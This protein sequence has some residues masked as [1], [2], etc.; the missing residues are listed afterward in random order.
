MPKQNGKVKTTDA[1]YLNPNGQTVVRR[2]DLRG[3]DHRQYIYVLR[4]TN[5]R[6]EYGANGSDIH[7]RKCPRC[8]GGAPGLQYSQAYLL[9]WNPERSTWTE[10]P[11]AARALRAGN[12][13]NDRWSCGNTT[14]IPIGARVF[15]LR[16]G[17]D[18]PGVIGSGWVSRSTFQAPHWDVARHADGDVANYVDVDFD[19]LLDPAVTPPLNVRELPSPILARVN[20]SSPSSGISIPPESVAELERLWEDYGTDATEIGLVDESIA[21]LEGRARRRMIVHRSRERTLR[22]AKIR[23]VMHATGGRLRCEVPGCG[24]DFGERYGSLG[25]GYA[26]VHHLRPLAS[27]E[28]EVTTTLNDLAVVCANCHAMLHLGGECRPLDALIPGAGG[29][30][31]PAK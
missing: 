13:Y 22:L 1:G 25:A 31:G 15:L 19:R 9:T 24:F 26:Q 4:C 23:S 30:R 27:V 16:Q 11:Q 12:P 8:Q 14:S 28:S 5:C 2:T 21:A 7:D 10:L 29:G 6:F 17:P 20:W 18:R 3:T